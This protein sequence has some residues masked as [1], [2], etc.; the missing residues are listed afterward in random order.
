M[1]E[2]GLESC[3]PGL[4]IMKSISTAPMQ[5]AVQTIWP[6]VVGTAGRCEGV[7]DREGANRIA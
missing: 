4:D 2:L 5:A 7:A 3:S 6:T 1:M